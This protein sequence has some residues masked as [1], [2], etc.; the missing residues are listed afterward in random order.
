MG[1]VP[2]EL[3]Q[4]WDQLENDMAQAVKIVPLGDYACPTNASQFGAQAT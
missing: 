3:M 4:K 2:L 1:P